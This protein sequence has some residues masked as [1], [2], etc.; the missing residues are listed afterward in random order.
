MI[1]S[2]HSWE[3]IRNAK[4]LNTYL[5]LLS[6]SCASHY[7]MHLG[8]ETEEDTVMPSRCPHSREGAGQR[9]WTLV[10]DY[11]HPR[12]LKKN[13]QVAPRSAK[14]E[15]LGVEPRLQDLLKALLPGD[16][17]VPVRLRNTREG[18]ERQISKD[19]FWWKH[20]KCSVEVKIKY[21]WKNT[22]AAATSH[23]QEPLFMLSELEEH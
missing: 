13:A 3:G 9:V 21:S 2:F 15:C 8:H 11:S 14:L 22:E 10:A 19:N 5:C 1:T 7:A 16:P 20:A 23:A 17:K 12:S 18:G 6:N 4:I